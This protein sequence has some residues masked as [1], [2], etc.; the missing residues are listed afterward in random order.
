MMI[1]KSPAR[2]LREIYPVESL[3]N[4]A[5]RAAFDPKDYFAG[6]SKGLALAAIT[7]A[8]NADEARKASNKKTGDIA[9]IALANVPTTGWLPK[10]LRTAH[11]DGP[12][13]KS[14]RK[15]AKAVAKRKSNA[16]P[17]SS[18]RRLERM[19]HSCSRCSTRP[20]NPG[21]VLNPVKPSL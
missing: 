20:P 16:K 17:K 10:E 19:T 3:M 21:P 5:L 2:L 12:A 9:K 1:Q 7:E 18:P 15:P 14:Q 4:A 8:V 13:G 6:V 11:Y